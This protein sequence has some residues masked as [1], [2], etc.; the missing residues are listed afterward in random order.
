MSA[1]AAAAYAPNPY[2]TLILTVPDWPAVAAALHHD[3]SFAVPVMV[4]AQGRVHTA[5]AAARAQGVT[6]GLRKRAAQTRSPG[7]AVFMRDLD[8]EHRVFAAGISV[9]EDAVARFSMVTPGTV[10]I[11]VS[12]LRRTHAAEDDMVESLLVHLTDTTGWEICPGIADSPFAALLAARTQTRVEPGLTAEFLAPLPVDTLLEADPHRYG[13]L[14]GLLHNLGLDRLGQLA[15]LPRADVHTRLQDTGV[16]AW[17]LARGNPDSLPAEH[18][19]DR[20]YQVLTRFDTPTGRLDELS[21]TARS[22]AASFLAEV[23][24]A[25][26]V[27]SHITISLTAVGGRTSIRTWRLDS[28]TES[29][30]ADRVRWQADGWLTQRTASAGVQESGSMGAGGAADAGAAAGDAERT[31]APEFDDIPAGVSVIELTAVELLAPL[32]DQTSLFHR[33]PGH[34]GKTLERLQGLFGPAAVVTPALQGG[35][36]PAETNLWTPWQQEPAPVRSVKAPWPG[37][38]PA[39][40]P[41]LVEHTPIELLDAYGNPVVARPAGLD[42]VPAVMRIPGQ[43]DQQIADFSSSWPVEAYWWDAANRQYRVRIQVVTT[44]GE[45][46]LLSKQHGQWAITG[47]YA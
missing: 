46:Y 42:S 18:I 43:R 10:S 9:L 39:P 22:L 26:L 14:V 20:T 36:D 38:V 35:R 12:S 34:V 40:R 6:A 37:S 24:A 13:E 29:A 27:C 33:R 15:A 23:R 7:A 45:A 19:R 2:R 41:T 17:N 25:G 30:I 4:I 47:R 32:A 16:R 44:A 31:E 3:I 1:E 5:N 21:F 11:P 28:P 8:I